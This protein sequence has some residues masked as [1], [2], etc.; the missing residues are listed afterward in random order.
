MSGRRFASAVAV[1]LL[2]CGGTA[3]RGDM[4][5]HWSFDSTTSPYANQVGGGTP[6]GVP[7]PNPFVG[8]DPTSVTPGFGY[9]LAFANLEESSQAGVSFGTNA[10]PVTSNYTVSAWIKPSAILDFQL[11]VAAWDPTESLW[12]HFGL[13]GDQVSDFWGEEG[14]ESANPTTINVNT[15]YH[16]A[17]VKDSSG[18]GS[19]R[20]FVD[21]V[22][23]V[24]V[25]GSG[26]AGPAGSELG[27]G[28]K[29]DSFGTGL[30]LNPFNGLIDDVAIWN[31]P[32]TEAKVRSLSMTPEV[33]GLGAYNAGAMNQL[34]GVFDSLDP[35]AEATVDGLTWRKAANLTTNAPGDAWSEGGAY[36]VKFGADS[37]VFAVPEPTA[38]ALAG[39]G[40]AGLLYGLRSRRR[41]AGSMASQDDA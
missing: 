25:P 17:S 15:W 34:F 35:L 12:M 18:F 22:G 41:R 40:A 6:N 36:Y 21:G 20:V 10:I 2:A 9:A 37:G 1:A 13:H 24:P 23:N 8:Q 31:A 32:L 7:E 3:T 16:V 14:G 39:C 26:P 29:Y 30:F 27:I 5:A 33:S 11:V 4:P 28:G 19:L 38:L